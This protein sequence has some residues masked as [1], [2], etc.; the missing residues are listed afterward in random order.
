MDTRIEIFPRE[1][2]ELQRVQVLRPESWEALELLKPK[3]SERALDCFSEIYRLYLIPAAPWVFGTIILFRLP[4]DVQ[5]P[6]EMDT[7]IFGRVHDPL[8]AATIG[9]RRGVRAVGKDFR[10]RDDR[11]KAFWKE[12]KQR[13]CLRI[14]RGKLPTTTVIPVGPEAGFLSET[15]PAAAMK[16]NSSFFIMDPFDCATPYDHIGAP[17]GL[18][19]KNGVVSA[20]PL[21]SREALLVG[22]DGAVEI[23]ALDVTDLA[24]EVGGKVYRHGENATIYTRPSHARVFLGDDTGLVIIGGH[25]A[26]VCRRWAAV[27]GSGFVLRIPGRCSLQPGDPVIYRGLEDVRFGIQVGNSILRDG[28]KT[29]Q[30]LSRF[31][32]VKGIHRT[33]FPPSLYPLDFDRARAAR[34]AIGADRKGAPMLLWAEGAAKLGHTP[35]VDSCGAS[36][37]E[38]AQICADVGMYNGVNLDGGGSAQILLQ[39]SRALKISDRRGDDASEKERPV[40]MGLIIR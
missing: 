27:P 24:V 18:F 5:V 10:F 35:G 34:I 29:E 38:M 2:G 32:N 31:F 4:E 39:N 25:V 19:V 20:P 30:F 14:V 16:V 7:G 17:F 8:T 11:V 15:E 37:R 12:L 1:Q 33:A 23:R 28:V 36:L 3:S 6:F 13:H 40:P 21:F 22:Q 9:L 26:A